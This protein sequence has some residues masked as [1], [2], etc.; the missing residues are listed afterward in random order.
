[1]GS[2]FVCFIQNQSFAEIHS[3]SKEKLNFDCNK[4]CSIFLFV[5]ALNILIDSN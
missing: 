3:Y 2:L 5:R 4:I 1:M